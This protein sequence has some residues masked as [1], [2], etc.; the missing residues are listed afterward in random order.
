M[1]RTTTGRVAAAVS[2][3]AL[4][5]GV[6]AT[7][8]G[9]SAAV[10]DTVT[11]GLIT[12]LSV[13]VRHDGTVFVSQNFAGMLTR[14][15]PGGA[16]SN[17]FTHPR[18]AEVG[19]VSVKGG[20]VT[21]AITGGTARKPATRVYTRDA[22]GRHLLADIQAFEERR[23][24]DG[25]KRYGLVGLTKRC[26]Q[27]IPA[28]LRPYKGIVES[29]PYAT[30]VD[31]TSTFLADAA[32]NAVFRIGQ[33]GRVRTVAVLPA[34][35]VDVTRRIAREQELPRCAA[36]GTMRLEPV[37]TDVERGDDGMLYVT[38]LPGGPEDGSLGAN[39]AVHRIDPAT[40]ERSTVARGLV[41]PVGLALDGEDLYVSQ[42]FASNILKLSGGERTVF[43]E[44]PFPGDVEVR[45]TDVYATET[46]LTND[47]STPP[48]GKVL[49][50]SLLPE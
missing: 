46:D 20:V 33:S 43:A 42:L 35:R 28:F 34:V 45:G 29:H 49:H 2:A 27:K 14:V 47:G 37:P 41:S 36:R 3:L 39:G 5:A 4:G 9:A 24:P 19:A 30:N 10:A 26:K 18:G 48:N 44:V 11:D 8:P 22:E 6:L 31:D 25:D 50:W 21:Y 40:G 38:T 23:N 17:I 15:A 12:P 32:A 13:A 16:T 7:G 1:S